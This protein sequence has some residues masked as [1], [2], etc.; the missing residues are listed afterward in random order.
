V[1]WG[2]DGQGS[3]GARTSEVG[4]GRASWGWGGQ[5]RRGPKEEAK[6]RTRKRSKTDDTH[7]L[8]GPPLPQ[9]H[10]DLPYVSQGLCT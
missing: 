4:M 3:T 1:G 10:K 2:G 8:L 7:E 6:D 9:E 5:A